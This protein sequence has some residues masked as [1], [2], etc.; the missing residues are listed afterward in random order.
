MK[1]NFRAQQPYSQPNSPNN[2]NNFR[3]RSLASNDIHSHVDGLAKLATETAKFRAENA[4]MNRPELVF[5]CGD[6]YV[7]GNEQKNNLIIKIMNLLKPDAVIPGNHEFDS[8]GSTG[9]LERLK[10]ANFKTLV[11]NLNVNPDG[12]MDKL[13]KSEKLAKSTVIE[14]NGEKIGVIGLTPA[15]LFMR[16]SQETK[17]YC[18][19]FTVKNLPDTIKAVQDEVKQLESRNVNKIYL[20]SHMGYDADV[21]MAKM[22]E[23]VDVIQG[24]HSHDTLPGLI[25]KV[26]FFTSRR[27]EPVIITQAGKNGH[28]YNILDVEFD[29]NG[30]IVKAKNEVKSLE[31]VS[32]SMLVNVAQNIFLGKPKVIGDIAV[33]VKALPEYALEENPLCS[34][35]CDAYKKYTGAD[36]VYNNGGTMRASVYKGPITDAQIKDLMPYFNEVSVYKFSEKEIIETLNNAIAAT[37]K[38]NRTGALQVAGIQ[39]TIGKDDKVK[40]VYFVKDDGTKEKIDANNPRAD[41]F[42]TVAYNSFLFGGSEGLAN[43]HAP[44]KKIAQADKNETEMLIEYIKSFNGKPI[45]IQKTGRIL[46]ESHPELNP[47]SP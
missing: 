35:L 29:K 6:S 1:I 17:D 10:G 4:K 36:I 44:E 47:K 27:G 31:N 11:A 43:L 22:L 24:A 32:E 12:N 37:K 2:N 30:K 40:D 7:G 41:K 39:Y 25:P 9:L 18:K 8:K 14:K 33:T 19:D 16:I 20:L 13:F 46:S 5:M 23:G 26:N 3:M 28:A 34:F 38:Y 15:D 45:T 21:A 42:Y